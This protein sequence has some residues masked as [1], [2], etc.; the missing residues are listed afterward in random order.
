MGILNVTPDSF[1]DGGK[2]FSTR[3]IA[4]RI[5]TMLNEGVDIIDIGACSTRPNADLIDE[6]E[7]INRIKQALKIVQEIATNI[8]ISVDTFRTS[9]A[10]FVVN[11]LGERIMINDI[12]GGTFD[13]EMMPFA[14]KNHL[15]YVCMHIQGTPK[16]MQDNP[17]YEDVIEEEISYFEERKIYAQQIGLQ[18]LILDPGFGFGKTTEQNY[19]LL[20]NLEKFKKFNL[21]ILVG[22]SRKSMI[23]NVLHCSAHE[24][25]N[26]T[27]ILNTIALLKGATILR[28]HDVKEAKEVIKIF[29]AL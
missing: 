21:P 27:T 12:S 25:L 28:V 6:K 29:S 14:A 17:H 9:V 8:P 19:I 22:L 10:Q 2:T 1:F 26:G 3:D 15:P 23:Q 11:E 7:E 4:K 5:D 16:T 13:K 20:N 18:Y 24:A